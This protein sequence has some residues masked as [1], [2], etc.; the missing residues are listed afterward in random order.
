[1]TRPKPFVHV[2]PAWLI[3][4]L[5]LFAVW[6]VTCDKCPLRQYGWSHSQA[7]S[8]ARLHARLHRGHIITLAPPSRTTEG[9]NT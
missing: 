7:M 6:R 8:Y 4:V 2:R 3:P 1:M 9:P 5:K